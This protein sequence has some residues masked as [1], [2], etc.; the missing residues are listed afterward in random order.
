MTARS[1]SGK[2]IRDEAPPERGKQKQLPWQV[3]LLHWA[4]DT[5]PRIP[6]TQERYKN[7]MGKICGIFFSA[8]MSLQLIRVLKLAAVRIVWEMLVDNFAKL[9]IPGRDVSVNQ[10]L[11]VFKY[12]CP[13]NQY[14][15]S[16]TE[17][18][19]DA[20]HFL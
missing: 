13:F 6:I 11:V 7:S 18:F 12:H 4:F 17:R 15:P 19:C 1:G 2:N 16:K 9:H 10:Q 3:H 5:C 8:T 14:I 20:L